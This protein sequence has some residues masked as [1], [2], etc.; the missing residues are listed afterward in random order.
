MRLLEKYDIAAPRYTSYP[1]V[2]YW[3]SQKLTADS[4]LRCVK[5]AAV[6]SPGISLYIH[7]PYCES[8]CTYCGCNKHITKNHRVETPYLEAILKEWDIYLHHLPLAPVIR[9]IH[10]GGG[11]PTFFTP[12]NLEKL[13]RGILAGARKSDDFE[14]GFEAHPNSTSEAHLQTLYDLGS[15]RISIGVQD[16]DPHILSLINRQQTYEEVAG[17]THTARRIGYT[18]INYDLIF[19]LP[20]Q[21]PSHIEDD[22]E[23]IKGLRPD[24]IAFYSYAHVPWIKPSQ[25]AYSEKD[26]P[27]GPEKRHLYELGREALEKLGYREIGMDHFALPGDSLTQ[28]LDKGTLHRNFMGYTPLY[29]RLSIGLGA[30][31]ISDTW[32]AFMQNEKTVG[33]YLERIEA[34]E[35]PILRGHLLNEEDLILRRHILNIM[36]RFETS[37]SAPALQ[38][39]FLETAIHQLQEMVADGLVELTPFHLKVTT[40]GRPFLRNI[41]LAFDA[42]FWNKQPEAPLFSKVM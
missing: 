33:D 23:K 18:S 21:Q 34:G 24:R 40:A 30:S 31:A 16:F 13:I 5:T 9:E 32:D 11:T 28:A 1:T 20:T 8:L 15:R 38:H 36:C 26:L 29:T 41:C 39:P 7:L 35:L 10:L 2:P 42:R 37:W 17:V 19:G 6:A 12:E 27:T 25:R 3:D 4:W 22:I 14:L